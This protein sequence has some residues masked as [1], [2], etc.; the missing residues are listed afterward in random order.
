MKI[1]GLIGFVA[2]FTV[3]I[4]E[5][6]KERKK[7]KK[8]ELIKLKREQEYP[9]AFT[10]KYKSGHRIIGHSASM[11]LN[12]FTGIDGKK[13]NPEKYLG[14]IICGSGFDYCGLFHGDLVFVKKD[15]E[16]GELKPLKF[17]SIQEDN[18]Y[19][20]RQLYNIENNIAKVIDGSGDYDTIEIEKI[21][22]IVE[23]DFYI[24]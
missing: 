14:L 20:V 19:L 11:T 12:N 18:Y 2:L 7:Y 3:F 4:W 16:I 22:G 23:Y 1:I 13:L 24:K 5:I 10:S 15:I 6:I 9:L 17:V 8:K 21:V